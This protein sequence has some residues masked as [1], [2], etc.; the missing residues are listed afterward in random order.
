MSS[1]NKVILIGR[2]GKKPE[3]K[4]VSENLPVAKFSLATSESYTDKEGKKVENTEWH[5]IV[6]WRKLAE[7]ADK[8]LDKGKQVYVEGKIKT[9]SYDDKDG[10]KKYITEIVADNFILLGSKEGTPATHVAPEM[11]GDSVTPE[12]PVSEEAD[13]LPF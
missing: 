4:Y 10:N 6:A 7:I 8:Y 3:I 1:L 12:I 2:L 5:N 13:D 9:R 11:N